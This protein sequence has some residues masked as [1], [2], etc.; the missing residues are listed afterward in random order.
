VSHSADAED[1]IVAEWVD[2]LADAGVADDQYHLITCPGAATPEYPKAVSFARHHN[3][4]AHKGDGEIVTTPEKFAEAAQHAA[5]NR[6]ATYEDW[7]EDDPVAI[8]R[9]AGLLR[10]EIEHGIQRDTCTNS[11]ALY[12]LT[13]AVIRHAVQ[14]GRNYRELFHLQPVE[15]DA[16]AAAS[17]FLRAHP[18]HHTVVPDLLAGVDTYLV[19]SELPPVSPATSPSSTACARHS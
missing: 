10:H 6:G 14:D 3:V 7:D 12:D 8:A 2:A 17:M 19:R 1:F 16:D 5:I 15:W 18:V 9:L 13:E 4:I 11:F